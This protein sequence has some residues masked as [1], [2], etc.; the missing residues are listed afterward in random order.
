MHNMHR[1]AYTLPTHVS[2]RAEAP[3][4]LHRFLGGSVG[5]SSVFLRLADAAPGVSGWSSE[6]C[7]RAGQYLCIY[8]F[9]YIYIYVWKKRETARERER[10]RETETE[11]ERVRDR[12]RE[13]ERE[14]QTQRQRDLYHK[15]I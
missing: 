6:V 14:S 11:R 5:S 1:Y 3:A 13:R 9:Y 8:H 15:H 7:V 12:D 4:A 2:P 10:E